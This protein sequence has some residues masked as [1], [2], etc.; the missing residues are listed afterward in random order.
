MILTQILE[1][2]NNYQLLKCVLS[3]NDVNL[4][5]INPVSMD[6]LSEENDIPFQEY[7]TYELVKLRVEEIENNRKM[8]I[9]VMGIEN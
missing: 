7:S 9:G 2:V 8:R 4:K 1:E 3:S 6:S 5:K